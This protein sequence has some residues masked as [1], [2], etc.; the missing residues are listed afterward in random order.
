[1]IWKK[2]II[3]MKVLKLTHSDYQKFNGNIN[4]L[5][6]K[7]IKLHHDLH[8]VYCVETYSD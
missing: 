6:E 5:M 1:M 2:F 8:N 3:A 7:D 4:L